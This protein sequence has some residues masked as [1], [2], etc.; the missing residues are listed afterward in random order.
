M[1]AEPTKNRLARA[2]M[3]AGLP[4]MAEKAIN[5]MYDDFESMSATPKIDLVRHLK[6]ACK[7]NL[8]TRAMNGEFDSTK[9]EAETWARRCKASGRLE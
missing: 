5:G 3:E 9:E 8:A 1:Q 7:P 6:M 2:L 4:G